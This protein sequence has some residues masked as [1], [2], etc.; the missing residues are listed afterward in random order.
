M[1]Y[2][3]S[4]S[5]AV[6]RSEVN[7]LWPGRDRGSDGWIGD[8]AHSSRLSDHN[9]DADGSVNA[10]DIDKDGIDPDHLR[11]VAMGDRRCN[12]VIWQ[13]LIYRRAGGWR[14]ERYSGANGHYQHLHVSILHGAGWE[15]DRTPWGL[16]AVPV[17]NAIGSGGW[18]APNLPTGNLPAPLTP[19]DDMSAVAEAQIAEI[20]AML[21][22]GGAVGIATDQTIAGDTRDIRAALSANLPGIKS[23]LAALKDDTWDVRLAL[24]NTLPVLL[25]AAARNG[26]DP[27]Q[28]TAA[29]VAAI[30]T[31]IAQDVLDG[32]AARLAS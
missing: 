3:L 30:P 9:P 8:A 18:T 14:P 26:V 27:A 19:E 10:L 5:L 28:I 29:V 15:N 2:F 17:S 6:L 32:L 11:R 31:D 22:A 23:A 1:A 4:P 16:S 12:Y 7:A 24:S 13:G 20:H 25:G 21:G